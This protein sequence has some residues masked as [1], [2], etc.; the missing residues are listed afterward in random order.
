MKKNNRPESD[1]S[2]EVDEAPEAT[3]E[4]MQEATVNTELLVPEPLLHPSNLWLEGL[5][6]PSPE[7]RH[8]NLPTVIAMAVDPVYCRLGVFNQAKTMSGGDSRSLPSHF[9]VLAPFSAGWGK[10][11]LEDKPLKNAEFLSEIHVDADGRRGLMIYSFD[12]HESNQQYKGAVRKDVATLVQ[13]GCT[14]R[15][16]TTTKTFEFEK[17]NK[18]TGQRALFPDVDTIHPFTLVKLFLKPN[19]ATKVDTP[20]DVVTIKSIEIIPLTLYSFV[21]AMGDF[22]ATFEEQ[23]TITEVCK[24]YAPE[25]CRP[26]SNYLFSNGGE[27]ML[28]RSVSS[29]LRA[30]VDPDGAGVTI[31]NACLDFEMGKSMID[32]VR[33]DGPTLMRYT[34][35]STVKRACQLLEIAASCGCLQLMVVK[36]WVSYKVDEDTWKKRLVYRAAPIIDF[37][38]LLGIDVSAGTDDDVLRFLLH[39][40]QTRDSTVVIRKDGNAKISFDAVRR[41]LVHET[42]RF[43]NFEE[44]G[45]ELK[46]EIIVRL[47]LR[48][49]SDPSK[50]LPVDP[51]V[52][53]D[54]QPYHASYPVPKCCRVHIDLG[55][56]LNPEGY[57]VDLDMQAVPNYLCMQ[58]NLS[59]SRAP[60]VPGMGNAT[61]E[62]KTC[63]KRAAPSVE[64]ADSF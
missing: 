8:E 55:P 21:P 16:S 56:K 54:W 5:A 3:A 62:A 25:G 30:S 46:R 11:P 38:R 28:L 24:T 63:R 27:V 39:A 1:A 64:D 48:V 44:D 6:L 18:K 32:E 50:E 49:L 58:L 19:N 20:G 41:C 2:M 59:S 52:S 14:L 40:P 17:Q 53:M 47:D 36:S 37:L 7:D 4:A 43:F 33:I 51:S 29:L 12:K 22:P 31:S 60:S 57:A 61:Q 35:C 15:L 34:N 10:A 26:C 9:V 23:K 45:K 13:A 42:H